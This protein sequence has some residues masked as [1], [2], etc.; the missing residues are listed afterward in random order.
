MQ[1]VK[2]S[3]RKGSGL[4]NSSLVRVSLVQ[5]DG[6]CEVEHSHHRFRDVIFDQT[7]GRSLMEK[8]WAQP[9]RRVAT[10]FIGLAGAGSLNL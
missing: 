3:D 2:C 8:A 5:I 10:N 4:V 9:S 6:F 7:I 1:V